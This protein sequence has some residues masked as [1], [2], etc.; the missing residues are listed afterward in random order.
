MDTELVTRIWDQHLLLSPRPLLVTQS[1]Q[2]Q[3]LSLQAETPLGKLREIQSTLAFPEIFP[4]ISAPPLLLVG[5]LDI[6]RR[7]SHRCPL[8]LPTLAPQFFFFATMEYGI[9]FFI[10][11]I[12]IH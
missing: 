2:D 8:I 3:R 9:Y 6:Q 7:S 10:R 12:C 5:N 4:S 1:P 11:G